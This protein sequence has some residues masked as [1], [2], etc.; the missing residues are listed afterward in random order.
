MLDSPE[1]DIA[2]ATEAAIALQAILAARTHRKKIMGQDVL[3]P[4][5]LGSA[6]K[7]PTIISRLGSKQSSRREQGLAQFQEL[8]ATL[9]HPTRN[10]VLNR[11]G[12]YDPKNLDWEDKRS[13]RRP[14]VDPDA[15]PAP[16]P[17]D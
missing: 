5:Q 17:S 7:L 11:I 15:D 1:F 10:K 9:S 14:V 4:G 6:L 8:W 3:I 16:N 13:N 2:T 12:W